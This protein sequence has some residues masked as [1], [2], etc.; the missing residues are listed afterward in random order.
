MIERQGVFNHQSS[1]INHQSRGAAMAETTDHPQIPPDAVMSKE[2]RESRASAPGETYRALSLMAMAGFGLAVLYALVVVVGGAVS[3]MA[4]IPWLMPYGTFLLPIA[5]LIVCR[6]ARTRILSS[7]GTLSGLAF[8]TW[9]SRLAILISVTYAAY[10]FATFLAVRGPAINCANEFL[11]KIKSG[12]RLQAFLMSLDIANKNKSTDELRNDIETRFNQPQGAPGGGPGTPGAFTRFS[13]DR[14]VRFL[15]M[16]GEQASTVL[17]GVAFWEYGKGGY[18]VLLN[19]HVVTSLVEFDLQVET[20]GRD[21]KPGEPKGRQWQVMVTRGLT[22]IVADTIQQTPRGDDFVQ[23]MRKA[24]QFAQDWAA[25]AG[26]VAELT[27]SE[28]EKYTKL[29]RGYETFWASP[30]QRQ[31]ILDRIRKSFQLGD[32]EKKSS[33][34]MALQPNAIPLLRESDG[35]TTA[36]TDVSLRYSEEGG[37]MPQYIVDGRL[38]LSADSREAAKSPSA[39]RVDALDIDSGRT[40]AEWSRMQRRFGAQGASGEAGSDKGGGQPKGPLRRPVRG[41]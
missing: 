11:Q 5:A 35:R 7:E 39:W 3:L 17:T 33:I 6:A 22:S 12:Q 26:D 16:D 29:I 18:R 4:H 30:T 32:G 37:T 19:Y 13:Q 2:A 27:P 24:Q 31:D 23:R 34:S 38:V 36:W 14:F 9:G 20:I 40:S 15:E 8:S 41:R 28:R 21:P 1:I 25:K 10:Y